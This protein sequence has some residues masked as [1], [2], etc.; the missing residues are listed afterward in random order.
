MPSADSNGVQIAYEVT[1]KGEPLLLIMGYGLPG[2]AWAL[3]LPFFTQKF[4][5]ITFDNRGTG[6]SDAPEEGYEVPVFARDALAVMDAAGWQSAHVF[7]VS[8][9]GM[10]AQQL[11]LDA[12]GRVRS[13]VLGC[14]TCGEPAPT[15]EQVAAVRQLGEAFRLSAEDPERAVQIMLPL[16][17]PQPFIDAHPEIAPLLVAGL[18]MMPTRKVPEADLEVAPQAWESCSRLH[19]LTMPALVLHGTEDRLIPVTHAQ[20]LFEGLPNVELRI[21]K[22]AGHAFQSH[23]PAGINTSIA[24]WLATRPAPP[25]PPAQG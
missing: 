23:D 4:Q 16:S 18:R 20:R 17:L 22:G 15:P 14:T 5:V 1:G 12:P 10:I 8:M 9:G 24:D 13:L 11:A 2:S 19:E 6:G 7:G 25:P 21:Y 3:S